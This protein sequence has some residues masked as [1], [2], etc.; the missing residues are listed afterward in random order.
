MRF[1]HSGFEEREDLITEG[2]YNPFLNYR[3]IA[4]VGGRL[5]AIRF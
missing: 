3:G 1:C 5:R 4:F 2:N